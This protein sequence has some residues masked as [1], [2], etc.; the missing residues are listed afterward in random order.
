MGSFIKSISKELVK[1]KE[2]QKAKMVALKVPI[3]IL[4]LN[5]LNVLLY[6]STYIMSCNV[7]HINTLLFRLIICIPYS[8]THTFSIFLYRVALHSYCVWHG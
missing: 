2:M 1:W 6:F 8:F 4:K 7:L 5:K 3:S